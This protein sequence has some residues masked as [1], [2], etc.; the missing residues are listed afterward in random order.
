M[1]GTHAKEAAPSKSEAARAD[2]GVAGPGWA[3]RGRLGRGGG[4][5]ER[6]GEWAGKRELGPGRG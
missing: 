2:R 3:A 1:L 6:E 4:K 5:G